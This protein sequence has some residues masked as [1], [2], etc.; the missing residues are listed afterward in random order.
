MPTSV[1]RVHSSETIPTHATHASA[2]SV[3]RHV[4]FSW[5]RRRRLL[6]VKPAQRRPRTKPSS[7][8]PAGAPTR[9][10]SPVH[11]RQRSFGHVVERIA[12][13]VLL[14]A[15]FGC[16]I[17][18]TGMANR[19]FGQVPPP[20]AEAQLTTEATLLSPEVTSPAS[21]RPA[22][23]RDSIAIANR[24]LRQPQDGFAALRAATIP[25]IVDRSRDRRADL[26][27][28]AIAIRWHRGVRSDLPPGSD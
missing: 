9:E 1:G 12:Y 14:L 16:V 18:L 2:R 17:A 22:P 15:L 23:G 13:V 19:P 26:M 24:D 4:G 6:R 25:P 10:E 27:D 7:A 28:M 11:L 21:P 3:G 5:R 20:A 8:G